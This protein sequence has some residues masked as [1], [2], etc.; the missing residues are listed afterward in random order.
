MLLLVLLFIVLFVLLLVTKSIGQRYI[1]SFKSGDICK[2]NPNVYKPTCDKKKIYDI[3]GKMET[4]ISEIKYNVIR[5]KTKSADYDFDEMY[6]W[7]KNQTKS[8]SSQKESNKNAAA[9]YAKNQEK[10]MDNVKKEYEKKN[11]DKFDK[12]ALKK[13]NSVKAFKF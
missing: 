7:Y 3:L 8:Q 2:K 9:R 5:E 10:E 4:S 11:R 12:Y 1:E 6:K 13:I